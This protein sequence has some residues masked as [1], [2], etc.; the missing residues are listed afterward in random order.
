MSSP[1]V[2]IY[3]SLYGTILNAVTAP[4]GAVGA[5]GGRVRVGVRRQERFG[6]GGLVKRRTEV[7]RRRGRAPLGLSQVSEESSVKPPSSSASSSP[8]GRPGRAPP[9]LLHHS[10]CSF[11]QS[12]T[13]THTLSHLTHRPDTTPL[14]PTPSPRPP[15]PTCRCHVGPEPRLPAGAAARQQKT[16]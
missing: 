8:G 16:K 5:G 1:A 3:Y 10:R 2:D 14:K 12:S 11:N 13:R 9:R 6:G 4:R 15:P 7:R